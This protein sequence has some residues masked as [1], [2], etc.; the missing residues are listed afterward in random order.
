MSSDA[1]A[2]RARAQHHHA[3]ARD[4]GRPDDL[5]RAV[6][7][8]KR[9]RG[10]AL[11]VVVEREQP[12]AVAR[13]DRKGVGGGEVLPLQ[14]QSGISSLHCGDEVLDDSSYSARGSACGASRGTAGRRGVPVV[15]AHVEQIGRVR[16]GG[17]RRSACRGELADRDAH[18]ADALVAQAEDALSV[19]HHDDVDVSSVRAVA[20]DLPEAVPV[21]SQEQAARPR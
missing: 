7:G 12:V 19:G 3:A 14:Q 13:E 11:D 16:A 6:Q 4:S 20:Q 1:D 8:A 17:C 18:A 10:G 5:R 9:H 2:R 15:G 21:L